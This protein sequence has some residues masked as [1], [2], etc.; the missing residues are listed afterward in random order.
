MTCSS[1]T[2]PLRH[3]GSLRRSGFT[4]IEVLVVV[5]IIALLVAI[6]LPA[7]S[8]ARAQARQV[9]CLSNL[10]QIG[11]GAVQYAHEHREYIPPLMVWQTMAY[12]ENQD[13]GPKQNWG[14][15]G[16]AGTDDMR[17]YYPKYAPNL[18]IFECP[19]AHNE[20]PTA[21]YLRDS[22]GG[23][24]GAADRSARRGNAYEY[25]PFLYDVV[26]RPLEFPIYQP[27]SRPNLRPLKLNLIKYPDTLCVT[28]DADDPGENL[29]IADPEDPHP[30]LK[31]G[32]M[33]FADGHARFIRAGKGSRNWND[34]SDR[35][36][37]R[38]RR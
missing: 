36:R 33:Q 3:M 22:Y 38:V 4:L 19:G 30:M 29:R 7:L 16:G 6:L 28:H 37:P 15:Y 11:L 10:K 31:G 5:A 18:E 26:Y 2:R 25:I 23:G 9:V 17:L 24:F 34:W 20:V 14:A 1:S 27:S 21:E 13:T 32:N 12:P 8:R 35:G